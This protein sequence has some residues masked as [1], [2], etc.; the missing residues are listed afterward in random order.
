[1]KGFLNE[2]KINYLLYH[3]AL[4]VNIDELR[5]SLVFIENNKE[6]NTYTNKIIF[7]LSDE[8]FKTENI[9]VYK[10]IPILFGNN[11]K[12]ELYTI[13]NSNLIFN[14][15]ILKSAF[16]LLSGYQEITSDKK[17]H[18][19]RFPFKGSL[20]DTL[21][22]ID[23]PIVNYYFKF[24]VEAVNLFLNPNSL[25]KKNVF[26]NYALILTHDIDH[27]DYY[28]VNKFLYKIKELLGLAKTN[29]QKSDILKY[30]FNYLS[31]SSD[32]P[33]W[34]FDEFIEL[35]SKYGFKSSFYFLKKAQ[36]HVDSTY[37][38]SDKKIKRAF[39]LIKQNACEIG[40]HGTVGSS[41]NKEELKQQK[42]ELEK[43]AAITVKGGRQHRLMFET[44][45]TL[46]NHEF[47]TLSYDSSLCFA[48]HEGFRNSFC[49][50]F[51]L[52]DFDND[53]MINVWEFPLI[54]MDTTLFHYQKYNKEEAFA[55]IDNL[56]SEI[57]QFS[58]VLTLLFHNGF[59]SAY[60]K[61]SLNNFYEDLL[62][63]LKKTKV[64]NLL[65]KDLVEKLNVVID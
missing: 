28:T 47:A 25:K 5:K 34:N 49:L 33:Y 32:N 41:K 45:S 57:K 51:K 23:K 3:L 1:M 65:A 15:D 53:K 22:I 7:L 14:H 9:F 61:A 19:G 27:V 20:H 38:F 43:Q 16:Y 13:E 2:N 36:K 40:L 24:I 58:G 60:P 26:N 37:N 6:I 42:A 29:L 50:P 54:A 62:F 55:A 8:E 12:K 63:N 44:P 17:D 35:E 48:E 18:F 59:E 64:E 30:M 21:K 52:Y 31:F 46:L 11:N 4:T 56:I 10:E 39:E